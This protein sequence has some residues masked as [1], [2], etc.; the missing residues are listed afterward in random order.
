MP[1]SY[2]VFSQRMVYT[3]IPRF[4]CHDAQ[5]SLIGHGCDYTVM[6]I[7]FMPD[8]SNVTCIY[9]GGHFTKPVV[10]ICSNVWNVPKIAENLKCSHSEE[11]ENGR[12]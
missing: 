2:I 1:L 9:L 12:K 3:V 8:E 5:H 10:C 4:I 6:G 7:R 11:D